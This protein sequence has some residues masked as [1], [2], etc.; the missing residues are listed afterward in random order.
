MSEITRYL[1]QEEMEKNAQLNIEIRELLSVA[2]NICDRYVAPDFY[3]S[4]RNEINNFVTK[5]TQTKAG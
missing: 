2:Q 4:A 3:S 5:Q 1:L